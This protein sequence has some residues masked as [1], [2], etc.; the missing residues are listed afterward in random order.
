MEIPALPGPR[1][2]GSA[3]LSKSEQ[4]WFFPFILI[5]FTH[6]IC[7][8][9][10]FLCL[11][12][13][14]EGILDQMISGMQT[15]DRS[16]VHL[17]WLFLLPPTWQ[18]S[19]RPWRTHTGKGGRRGED[20]AAS[21]CPGLSSAHTRKSR[22]TAGRPRSEASSPSRPA[23]TGPTPARSGAVDLHPGPLVQDVLQQP[24]DHVQSLILLQHNV[25]GVHVAL[26]LLLHLVI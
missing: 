21:G 9:N 22:L 26:T 4:L 23:G 10:S 11:K 6:S 12:C 1:G 18:G 14:K 24:V 25:I 20:P 16:T 2:T 15:P 3:P 8:K 5:C 7:L 19:H 17:E 13:F